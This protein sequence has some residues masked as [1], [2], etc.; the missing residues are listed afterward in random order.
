MNLWKRLR[1]RRIVRF[2]VSYSAAGWL[3]L[4]LVDQ[5]VDRSVLPEIT[6][7]ATLTLFL[8]L[9]PGAA[10]VSWFHGEKGH[11]TA[12]TIEKWM[13]AGVGVFAL[14]TTGVVVHTNVAP[15]TE[16]AADL[17]LE[18]WEDPRRVAVLYF[19]SRG[20][21]D[22]DEF[23]AAGLTESLIDELG[24][25]ESLHVVSRN[26]SM[27]YRNT[28]MEPREI[29]R[30]LGVGLLVAGRVEAAGDRVRVTVE[31]LE[32]PTGDRLYS[33][34]RIERPRGEIFELH[35]ELAA[36]V[37]RFLR[38]RIG[39]EVG[40][41]TARVGTESEEAWA[42]VQRARLA[43]DDADALA[44][45][46]DLEAASRALLRADSL[47]ALAEG[48]DPEWVQP[49]LRRGWAAYRQARLGGFDRRHYDRWIQ[50]GLE[51]AD[52]ALAIDPDRSRALELR[53]TLLYLRYLMNFAASD[54][55]ANALVH[56]AQTLL[57]RAV[58]EDRF[59][60]SAWTSLSHLRAAQGRTAEAKL[61]ARTSYQADPYLS[62]VDVTL[63]RLASLSWDSQ[64]S[65][66]TE[67][68]CEEGLRRF[69]DHFRF[70]QCHL[71]LF[72]L[73]D[74][75][76]D[77]EAAWRWQRS[78]VEHAPPESREVAEKLS[79]AYTSMALARAGLPDSARA[80]ARR[81]RTDPTT[82]PTRDV[83]RL[84]AMTHLWLGDPE[85]ATRRLGEYLAANPSQVDAYRHAVEEGALPW[86]FTGLESHPRFRGLVAAR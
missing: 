30:E 19:D 24:G 35:D 7:G 38:R 55:E 74:V 5:L 58:S 71:M 14:A 40:V 41:L 39:D 49:P 79:L 23:L 85:A 9:F 32:S 26:G 60:A 43:A 48:A 11:Q 28:D 63:W 45:D 17:S 46:E 56:E 37:S 21:G 16:G 76:P 51:H 42:L 69:P 86:Y 83:A 44:A 20:G 8:T 12:P 70:H 6:Y 31:M 34:E 82:D 33:P 73:P 22:D 54:E 57:E 15:A 47:L 61:A 36:Q 80:V 62:N 78:W 84:Q 13:L 3:V 77:V 10:I 18:P 29:G 65:F 72:A 67:R 53:G 25:V 59:N 4:Q 81:S 2:L 64:D 1:N 75:A 68:W 66:E 52:R 50:Q 27:R